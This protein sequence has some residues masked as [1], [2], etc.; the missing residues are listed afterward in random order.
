MLFK[1]KDTSVLNSIDDLLEI[2]FTAWND[3]K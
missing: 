3:N 1:T 2:I